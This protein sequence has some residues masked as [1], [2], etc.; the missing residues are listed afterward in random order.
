MVDLAA[1][2]TRAERDVDQAILTSACTVTLRRPRDP[3]GAAVDPVT[4]VPEDGVQAAYAQ[5][6]PA[7]VTPA[8]RDVQVSDKLPA[9]P[10]G[11][12]TVQVLLR[13]EDAVEVQL[14]D[15]VVVE[16][17]RDAALVGA[18]YAVTLIQRSSAGIV[19]LLSA[20]PVTR[21]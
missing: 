5:G 7:I 12:A 17:S 8:T 18:E 2:L 4:L 1:T 9:R 21:P 19:V 16:T 20:S 3:A 11:K 6:V 10:A 13:D 14:R 15:E